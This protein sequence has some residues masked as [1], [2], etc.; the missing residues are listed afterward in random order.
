MQSPVQTRHLKHTESSSLTQCKTS[1]KP[2]S[3]KYQPKTETLL[4]SGDVAD[5]SIRNM[6]HS[7]WIN[8]VPSMANEKLFNMLNTKLLLIK[9]L[10]EETNVIYS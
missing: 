10:T 3:K 5:D 8:Q 7:V 2:Y 9:K 6:S 4:K 1:N